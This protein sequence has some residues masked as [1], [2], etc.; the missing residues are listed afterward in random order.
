MNGWGATCGIPIALAMVIQQALPDNQTPPLFDQIFANYGQAAHP[1]ADVSN[2]EWF[3][4]GTRAG[5]ITRT[6]LPA[7]EVGSM[8][9]HNAVEQY[10]KLGNTFSPVK[11][12]Q[13]WCGRLVADQCYLALKLINNAKN[14]TPYDATTLSAVPATC[15]TAACHVNTQGR[16]V[17]KEDCLVC[18]K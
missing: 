15:H 11:V 17:G 10:I 12:R 14:G 18:H 9:C 13:E 6:P 3:Y 4:N 7:V 2:A 16:V 8:Q 5:Q 1:Q